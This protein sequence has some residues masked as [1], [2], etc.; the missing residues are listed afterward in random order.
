MGFPTFAEFHEGLYGHSPFPWQHTLAE[1][2]AAEGWPDTIDIPTGLG[3]TRTIAIAVWHLAHQIAHRGPRT[4]PLRILHVVDRTTIVDQTHRDLQI[5]HDGLHRADHRSVAVVAHVLHEAFGTPLVIGKIHGGVADDGEWIAVDTPTVIT[6]TAHQAVSRALFRGFG[7]SP[8]MAP[9]HAALL[10]VD[11]LIL[12]DEPHLSVAALSTLRALKEHQQAHE[13]SVPTGKTVQIGATV[14]PIPDGTVH[15]I[16]DADSADPVAARRLAA[17]K[18]LTLHPCGGTDKNTEDALVRAARTV[19]TMTEG[20]IAVVVNTVDMAR[21][22]HAA[23]TS[24]RNPVVS[25]ED[26]LLVTSRIRKYERKH[27]DGRL[28]GDLM[29]RLL[30]ATQTVEAG[31]DF[32]V[33]MLVTEVCDWQALIQRLGRLNRR[34]EFDTATAH[35]VIPEKPRPGTMAVYGEGPATGLGELLTSLGSGTHLSPVALADIAA[36]HAAAVERA[37]RPTPPVPTLIRELLPTIAHSRPVP[38]ADLTVQRYITGIPDTER[39]TDVTVLWRHSLDPELARW[40]PPDP[41]EVVTV[42]VAAVNALIADRVPR[43][44]PRAAVIA[45]DGESAFESTSSSAWTVPRSQPAPVLVSDGKTWVGAYSDRDITPGATIILPSN[46]GGH[47][48]TGFHATSTTP[49]ID[50]SATLRWRSGRWWHADSNS[51]PTLGVEFQD[52]DFDQLTGLGD[53]DPEEIDELLPQLLPEH[54]L[55][56]TQYGPLTDTGVWLRAP[57]DQRDEHLVPLADHAAQVATETDTAARRV[58]LAPDTTALLVKAAYHHDDGKL[59]PAFQAALGAQ[60][61]G[62]PLAKL[63]PGATFRRHLIPP[64]WRHESASLARQHQEAHPLVRHVIAAHHGWARPLLPAAEGPDQALPTADTFTQLNQQYGVWGLAWLETVMRL[65]DHRASRHPENGHTPP[66]HVHTPAALRAVSVDGCAAVELTGVPVDSPLAWWAT[67]GALAAATDLDPDATITYTP[68]LAG[69]IATIHTTTTLDNIANQVVTIA[70]ELGDYRQQLAIKNEKPPA[71][72]VRTTVAGLDTTGPARQILAS[73][74]NDTAT[75]DANGKIPLRTVWIHNNSTLIGAVAKSRHR[76]EQI[77]DVLSR[78]TPQQYDGGHHFGMTPQTGT[79]MIISGLPEK[80]VRSPLQTLLF[81]ATARLHP[82][83]GA[84]PAGQTRAG[85]MHLPL[86]S[87]PTSWNELVALLQTLSTDKR[88][89]R[90]V[91]VDHLPY[92]RTALDHAKS[93]A[94]ELAEETP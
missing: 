9:V 60:P 51:L 13:L 68:G 15:R 59:D 69:H 46:I 16:T 47:D 53:R 92:Q 20:S 25:E 55:G 48:A 75:P 79:T 8:A 57:V 45:D 14:P 62:P 91:G 17:P 77:T 89:W 73:I 41:G 26:A 70:G 82:T 66:N 35:V 80:N 87:R 1:R 43:G 32:S 23:L 78:Q 24:G 72:W 28:T 33:Q 6:M 11:S 27:Q 58:G 5:L 10:G 40:M 38:A 22:V 30:V 3:K 36:E 31:I 52:I 93:H 85:R 65:A 39:V 94:W 86:P 84:R 54:L 2:V 64:G 37:T 21:K 4:A 63:A 49:V 18:T 56:P 12:L 71:D 67:A 19:L 34:G 29:P 81:A 50:L 83:G 76:S 88:H 61:D 44:K 74:L 90:S 42:P 7:V